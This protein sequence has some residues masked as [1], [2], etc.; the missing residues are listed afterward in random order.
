[1]QIFRKHTKFTCLFHRKP[2]LQAVLLLWNVWPMSELVCQ[3]PPA[4]ILSNRTLIPQ[5]ASWWKTQHTAATESSKWT[6]SEIA[7]STRPKN[8]FHP[9]EKLYDQRHI[10]TR[11]N[12]LINFQCK[13]CRLPLPVASSLRRGETNVS[14]ILNLDCSINFTH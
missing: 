2:I 5:D 4:A 8:H 3:I 11:I 9:S 14:N 12:Q 1:M 7:D 10:K 6:G 13:V